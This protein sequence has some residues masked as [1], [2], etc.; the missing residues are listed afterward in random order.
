MRKI[1]EVLRLRPKTARGRL[2]QIRTLSHTPGSLLLI[3]TGGS[4]STG[5][6]P[7]FR[8][9]ACQKKPTKI[10]FQGGNNLLYSRRCR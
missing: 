3:A 10:G 9:N 7:H 2:S 5:T 8:R 4:T 1:K 6:P